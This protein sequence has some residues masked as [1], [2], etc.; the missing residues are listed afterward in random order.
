M[1]K[2]RV[3]AFAAAAAVPG[4]MLVGQQTPAAAQDPMSA[5]CSASSIVTGVTLLGNMPK[6]TTGPVECPADSSGC[7][8]SAV[9]HGT[10]STAI[11]PTRCRLRLKDVD[12]GQITDFYASGGPTRCNI[13]QPT[14]FLPAGSRIAA[15]CSYTRANVAL[16]ATI[17]CAAAF[18]QL[19]G[20]G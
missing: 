11:G 20:E 12:T 8:F 3:A 14:S 5:E 6:C 4:L 16:F 2:R 15:T 18:E 9:L 1:L 17:N 13:I 10:S 19:G 7:S